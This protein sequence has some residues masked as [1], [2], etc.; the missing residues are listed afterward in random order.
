MPSDDFYPDALVEDLRAE[1]RALGLPEKSVD[2]IIAHVL[3]AV[4]TWLESRD[5]ITK[6]DLERVVGA[7]LDKC[8]PDLAFVYKHRD[9][10]I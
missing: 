3:T 4:L 2:S 6:S 9:K 10:I 8:A 7:E 5:I 1:S